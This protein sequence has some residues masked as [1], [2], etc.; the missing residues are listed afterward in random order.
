MQKEEG[1]YG[2]TFFKIIISISQ[3]N[4]ICFFIKYMVFVIISDFIWYVAHDDNIYEVSIGDLRSKS[5][6]RLMV[7]SENWLQYNGSEYIEDTSILIKGT[8]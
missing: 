1:Q 2:N 4:L 8:Y 3:V 7:P 6:G 5:I